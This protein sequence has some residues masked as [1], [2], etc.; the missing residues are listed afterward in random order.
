MVGSPRLLSS[1]RNVEP[2]GQSVE[3]L[4]HQ[5]CRYMTFVFAQYLVAELL[6]EVFADNENY[7]PESCLDG[8]V[9][10][11]VHDGLAVWSQ[12]VKLFQTA[13][14]ASHSCCEE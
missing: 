1:F 5:F 12:T 8:I 10:T 2:F 6:F 7:F 4:E 13:V 3:A 11:V 14:A 9:D